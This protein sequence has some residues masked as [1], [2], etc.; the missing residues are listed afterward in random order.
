LTN[1]IEGLVTYMPVS[2]LA[3]GMLT[4]RAALMPCTSWHPCLQVELKV[5]Q[6]TAM[7]PDT[8]LLRFDL[9]SPGHRLGLHVGGHVMVHAPGSDGRDIVR[10]YTPI[11]LDYDLGH[12]DL[13][14]KV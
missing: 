14:I 4:V 6:K 9:A 8:V 10:P 1:H 3:A 12:M 5:T 11:T 13:L 7:S 2:A